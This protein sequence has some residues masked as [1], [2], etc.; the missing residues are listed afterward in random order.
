MGLTSKEISQPDSEKLSSSPEIAYRSTHRDEHVI[1]RSKFGRL[2]VRFDGGCSYP[3]MI[4]SLKLVFR[5]FGHL[6]V[7][8]EKLSG[9]G[10]AER[11]VESGHSL[12]DEEV[13]A[14]LTL[15]WKKT[16]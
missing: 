10:W 3:S 8:R 5:R 13:E 1:Q 14:I 9:Q 12:S 15:M 2:T 6:V 11:I 7:I 16:N 4:E